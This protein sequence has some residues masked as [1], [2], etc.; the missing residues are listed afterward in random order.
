[1][2]YPRFGII[3]RLHARPG[4]PFLYIA[5]II[6]TYD[7]SSSPPAV[8]STVF[9]RLKIIRHDMQA[10]YTYCIPKCT[11]KRARCDD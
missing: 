3:S 1:M 9:A 8:F 2:W 6:H 7:A 10:G 4:L 5:E 11:C